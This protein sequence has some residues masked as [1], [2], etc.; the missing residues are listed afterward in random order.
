M[1]Y[2]L[3]YHIGY[4]STS[5]Q[6]T[7]GKTKN[8]HIIYKAYDYT[9]EY[10]HLNNMLSYYLI[11]YNGKLKGKLIIIYK[12]NNNYGTIIDII[13]VASDDIVIKTL[14]Y[15]YNIYRKNSIIQFVKSASQ[16]VKN[17][18]EN[19][20]TREIINSYVFSIDPDNCEDIDDAISF[21]HFEN[22]N[23][24]NVYIAQP[25]YY[26]SSNILKSHSLN[27]FSTLYNK[28][29]AANTNLWGDIL[30]HDTSLYENNIRPAYMVSYVINKTN[31]SC[32]DIRYK[33]V[34]I[35]NKKQL[36]YDNCLNDENV[37]NCYNFTKLLSNINDTH[38]F[39]NYWMTKTNTFIGTTFGSILNLPYRVITNITFND[40]F[41]N[42]SDTQVKNT[43]LYKKNQG[44]YYSLAE[45]YHEQLNVSYYVHFTSPIRRLIDTIIHWCITYSINFKD[46]DI[47]INNINMFDKLIKKYHSNINLLNMINKIT[48]CNEYEGWIYK[49][50]WEECMQKKACIKITVYFK[51]FGFQRVELWNKKLYNLLSDDII[52][53][54][55]KIKIGTKYLFTIYKKNGFLP[56]EQILII[57]N[58]LIN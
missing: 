41:N 7:Y 24:I 23:I 58:D 31:L 12:T 14:Q 33:P 51:E 44:A 4:L 38:E 2:V 10:H 29:Y 27:S 1:T 50:D 6:V 17:D 15:I 57:M 16:L 8:N 32:D 26:L 19:N 55:N 21:E 43:F 49:N 39:I 18:L 20:I 34:Y 28:P 37:L 56:K 54:L 13:G 47:D 53:K 42:I 36:T 46:L 52:N 25:I 30:T 40:M 48:D 11:P 3:Q 9:I 22:Y 5:Q 45:S 35:I